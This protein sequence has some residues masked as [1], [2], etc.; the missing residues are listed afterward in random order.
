MTLQ[1]KIDAIVAAAAD[2]VGACGELSQISDLKVKFLGKSG[3]LTALLRGM[4]ELPAEE[5][6][7]AG[8][9]VNEARDKINALIDEK[10]ASLQ[11]RKEQ[12]RLKSESLDV[13]LKGRAVAR[14]SLHPCTLVKEEILS[15]FTSL[16]F[17]VAHGPEV[18]TDYYNFRQL[19]IPKDHPARDM[20]DTRARHAGHFLFG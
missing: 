19:N 9:L 16:G 5:R 7:A 4:K 15:I 11:A 8:K 17:S 10:F 6:P 1:E 2:G 13:T 18:E 3:E 20:Q 12:E 14:G